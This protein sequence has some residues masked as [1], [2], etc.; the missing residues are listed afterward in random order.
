MTTR[1]WKV[2]GAD[3]HRQAISFE[4]SFKWDFSENGKSRI[5]EVANADKTGTNDYSVVTI[6]CNT[7][8]ECEE[9]L[10]G[11]ITDGLFENVRTGKVEEI[12]PDDGWHNVYGSRVYVQGGRVVRGI[13]SDGQCTVYPYRSSRWGG[14]DIDTSM[15]LAA[16]RAGIRRGTVI[17]T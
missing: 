15:T 5:I 11:Q 14:Y 2:Y 1:T 16:L 13:S 6:T 7:F 8:A 12:F 4:P 9:E 10:R 3:G 17:L